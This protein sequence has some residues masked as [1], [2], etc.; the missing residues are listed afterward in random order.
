MQHTVCFGCHPGLLDM[1]IP[2]EQQEVHDEYKSVWENSYQNFYT[3]DYTEQRSE[4]T[5]DCYCD[6]SCTI[7]GDC[8]GDHYGCTWGFSTEPDVSMFYYTL[9]VTIMLV[10]I[11]VINTF[12]LQNPSPTSM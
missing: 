2:C 4:S 10:T 5:R 3:D 1:G 9:S 7:F 12:A 11:S 6:V 8:C